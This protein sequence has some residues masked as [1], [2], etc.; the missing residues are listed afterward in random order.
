MLV[1]NEKELGKALNDNVDEI[2][3]EA[4]LRKKV[5]KI[6][7]KGKVAWVIAIGSISLAVPLVMVTVMSAGT[8]TPITAPAAVGALAGATGVLGV[9]ATFSAVSIAAGAVIAAGSVSAGVAALNKL[10][11]YKMTDYGDRLVLTRK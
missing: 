7:A 9:G 5:I 4:N 8:A 11:K 10:R 3:I 6:K 1:T 2:E